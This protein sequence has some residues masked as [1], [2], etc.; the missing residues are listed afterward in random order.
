MKGEHEG[1][2]TDTHK[3]ALGDSLEKSYLLEDH[4][5]YDSFSRACA[6][7][8]VKFVLMCTGTLRL[9]YRGVIPFLVLF[10]PERASL[11]L[12]QHDS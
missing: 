4:V 11:D 1:T 10:P 9:R 3:A 5:Y 7:R 8:P 2:H 6:H 12:S